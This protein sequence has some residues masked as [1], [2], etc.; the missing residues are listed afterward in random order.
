MLVETDT[1]GDGD[2]QVIDNEFTDKLAVG[3]VLLI[4]IDELEEEETQPLTVFVTITEN[5]PD[6]EATGLLIELLVSVPEAGVV[7]L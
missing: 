4:V 1:L 6:P 2:A 5:T 7:Q 3:I